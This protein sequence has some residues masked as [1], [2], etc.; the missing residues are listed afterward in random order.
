MGRKGYSAEFR[1]R[2]QDLVVAGKK[3]GEVARLLEVSE[4]SIC[5]WRRAEGA[6]SIGYADEPSAETPLRSPF[7]KGF[8]PALIRARW[9]ISISKTRARTCL[10]RTQWLCR[11]AC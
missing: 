11:C 5:S 1:R 6:R 4:Q 10:G 2:A 3:V 7:R 8:E 9:V